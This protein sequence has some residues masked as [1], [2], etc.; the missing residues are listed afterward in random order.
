MWSIQ[1]G[2]ILRITIAA[3]CVLRQPVRVTKIRAGRDKPGLRPQHLSGIQVLSILSCDVYLKLIVC[4]CASVCLF[5]SGYYIKK[6][7]TSQLV[8]QLCGAR[9]SGDHTGSSEVTFEPGPL[10]GGEFTADTHT[11]G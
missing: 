11:A 7:P 10:I 8:S 5:H 1:G 9:L 3:S 4:M 6:N 2:Q